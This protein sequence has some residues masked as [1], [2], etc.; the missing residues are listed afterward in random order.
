MAAPSLEELA[1]IPLFESLSPGELKAARALFTIRSYA[2]NSIV[3]VEGERPDH[4]NFVLSGSVQ[5]FWRDDAGHQLKLGV[6]GP[7]DHYPDVSLGG[8]P[9]LVW[10]VAISEMRVAS[11][12]LPD[13]R[14]LL[15]RHPDVTFALLLDF[16]ARLRRLLQRTKM[17][18]MEDVYGRVVKL[19]LNSSVDVDGK[20]IAESLTH[21][22][23]GHRVGATREMVG[24]ILRD[25]ARGGYIK[26]ERGRV[27]VLKKPPA[28]W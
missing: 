28:R 23:I 6:D 24:R 8:E 11:I 22:E 17:L 12:R 19:L 27:M 20:R 10:R 18:T 5:A 13:L 26:A 9:V 21:A 15:R 7:G 14:R 25:L 3:A 4:F 1:A 16:V 2:K